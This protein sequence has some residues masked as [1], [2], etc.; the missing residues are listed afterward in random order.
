LLAAVFVTSVATVAWAGPGQG[1]KSKHFV[2]RPGIF[3]ELRYDSNVFRD[4]AYDQSA[5]I[6]AAPMFR[7]LPEVSLE[8]RRSKRLELKGR[9][10]VDVRTYFSDDPFVQNQSHVGTHLQLG[11]VLA[12][13]GVL[14][15]EGSER[16]DFQPEPGTHNDFISDVLTFDRI[17]NASRIA[18]VIRPGGGMLQFRAGYAYVTNRYVDFGPGDRSTHTLRAQ[19]RWRFLPKTALFIQGSYGWRE[20]LG[21]DYISS[22]TP[23]RVSGGVRGLLTPKLSLELSGGYGNLGAEKGESFESVIGRFSARYRISHRMAADLSYRRD[24]MD[25]SWSNYYDSHLISV[26]WTQQI[27]G[28]FVLGVRVG[29]EYMMFSPLTYSPELIEEGKIA[30]REGIAEDRQDGLLRGS[31]T[32]DWHPNE[33]L[34]I[35]AGYTVD[36]R[37]SSAGARVWTEEAD[38]IDPVDEA[39]YAKHQVYTRLGVVY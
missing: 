16:F 3:T 17:Y 1:F 32:L 19:A 24:F 14:S 37:F 39:D 28:H 29:Y 4:S 27:G 7:V 20:F 31:M 12:K 21:T 15:L 11:G 36:Q 13:E 30:V 9:A 22:A 38:I 23:L 10:Q 35:G 8:T 6:V 33:W 18:A 2:L 5:D 34:T 26:G 25:T